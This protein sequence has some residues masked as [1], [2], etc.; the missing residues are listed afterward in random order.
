MRCAIYTA[1]EQVYS[2]IVLVFTENDEALS[3]QRMKRVGNNNLTC[4]NSGI[5][6][7]LPTQ[8]GSVPLPCTA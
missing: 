7:C 8:A 2:S 1:T 6:D 4:Q 3:G 5:M